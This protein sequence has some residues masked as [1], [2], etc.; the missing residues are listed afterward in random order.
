MTDTYVELCITEEDLERN[1][2]PEKYFGEIRPGRILLTKGVSG[3]GKTVMT[4][5]F[6]RDWAQ[7]EVCS[8]VKFVFPFTF[9]EMNLLKEKSFT[10][11]DIIHCFFPE[12]KEAGICNFNQL[13][14][15]F[16]LDGLNEYFLPLNFAANEILTSPND[17][18]T[19]NV[20]ITNLIMGH[21]FPSASV[22]ITTTP[23]AACQIPQEYIHM[24]TELRGFHDQH[25]EEYFRK[26]FRDKKLAGRIITSIKASRRLKTLCQ[27]PV[28]C[29]ITATVLEC[30]ANNDEPVLPITVTEMYIRFTL[31][32][33]KLAHDDSWGGALQTQL[34]NDLVSLGKLAFQQLQKENSILRQEEN[35]RESVRYIAAHLESCPY[36]FQAD[37]GLG[38][39][40]CF[41]FIHSSVQEFLA[42][43]Y[44]FVSSVSSGVNLLSKDPLIPEQPEHTVGLFLSAVDMILHR[45]NRNFGLFP[46]FLVGLSMGSNQVLLQHL[47][48]SSIESDQGIIQYIKTKIKQNPSPGHCISLFQ[49]LSELNDKSLEEEIHGYIT[50]CHHSFKELSPIHWA[51]L[52]FILLSSDTK[53]DVFYL[54]KFLVPGL[55]FARVLPLVQVSTF[56]V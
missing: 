41:Y 54:Q 20:L 9:R 28:F 55:Q 36:L 12:T 47:L 56:A 33:S 14:I 23:E 10:W 2:Q 48:N 27:I 49:C 13:P 29:W 38:Q 16:V 5:K 35:L 1:F 46:L 53:L 7:D 30:D 39:G 22:W 19:I 6:I 26:K 4:Q 40:Q 31:V 51:S 43:L 17:L 18:A 45:G 44:V 24:A 52:V 8:D 21:L 15:V 11:I 32:Q 34:W 37:S 42:A 25:I 50:Q 3:S